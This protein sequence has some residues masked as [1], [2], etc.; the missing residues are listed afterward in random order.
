MRSFVVLAGELRRVC[1][2]PELTQSVVGDLENPATVDDAVGRLE[3][4]V[5]LDWTVV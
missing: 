2:V 4:T 1:H 3:V 5:T